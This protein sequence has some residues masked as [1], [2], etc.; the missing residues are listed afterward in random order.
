MSLRV[1][2]ITKKVADTI[3]AFFVKNADKIVAKTGYDLTVAAIGGQY[4]K[5]R[6]VIEIGLLPTDTCP[7]RIDD[8]AK[9]MK[10]RHNA[11]AYNPSI[12]ERLCDFTGYSSPIITKCV[13][14]WQ[15]TPGLSTKA[16][17]KIGSKFQNLKTNTKFLVV[18]FNAEQGTVVIFN[19]RIKKLR[20][21]SIRF[22]KSMRYL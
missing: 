13:N 15:N 8:L 5:E 1:K 22:V 17:F 18:G 21:V 16:G 14:D 9:D 10:E 11:C 3:E 7:I 12:I 2:Y 6:I 19:A 20:N 4:N